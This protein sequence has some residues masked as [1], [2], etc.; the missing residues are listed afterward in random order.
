MQ[1]PAI[2][3]AVPNPRRRPSVDSARR[4]RHRIAAN[5]SG[6][7]VPL[8]PPTYT[9]VMRWQVPADPDWEVETIHRG[10][11]SPEEAALFGYGL[12]N[13]GADGLH[14]ESGLLRLLLTDGSDRRLVDQD[15]AV[16]HLAA[17]V[18]DPSVVEDADFSRVAISTRSLSERLGFDGELVFLAQSVTGPDDEL[19]EVSVELRQ[20]G[21]LEVAVGEGP[22]RRHRGQPRSIPVRAIPRRPPPS[23]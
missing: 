16:Y 8:R 18:D 4:A 14:L 21:R 12:T 22:S 2:L 6:A 11:L 1:R 3:T 7:P 5:F 20:G 9:L 23:R 17:H 13:P 15:V 19:V 10:F